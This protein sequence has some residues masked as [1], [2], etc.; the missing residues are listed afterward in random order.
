MRRSDNGTEFVNRGC[1]ALFHSKSILHKKSMI[2]TP[3]QNGV[4]ERKLR[5]LLDTT[6]SLRIHANLP[7][8][9]WG[10]C[11]L[12]ATYLINKMPME[13]L[14]WKSPFEVLFGT[15]PS[16]D[17]LRTIG[18]LCFANVTKPHKDKFVARATKCVFI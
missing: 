7:L 9:F 2:Y 3:Q 12:A 10:D 13:N 14:N 8:F 15:V 16:Y 11:I 4:V 6:R 5:H 1:L 18:Y 17:H